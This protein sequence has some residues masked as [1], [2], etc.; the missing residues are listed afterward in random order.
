MIIKNKKKHAWICV[1]AIF[2][3]PLHPILSRDGGIG[4]HEGLK[5]LWPVM[6]VRV[7]VPLAVQKEKSKSTRIT[8]KCFCSF[9]C[10]KSYFF[11]KYLHILK[12][13]TTFAT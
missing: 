7:Q 4:R 10:N 6:A 5:I 11:Q 9:F 3:V 13:N 2:V 1:C 12:K 8:Q